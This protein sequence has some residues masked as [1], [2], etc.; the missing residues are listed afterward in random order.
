MSSQPPA[1]QNQRRCSFCSRDEDAVHRLIAGPEGVFICNECVD[2]CQDILEGERPSSRGLTPTTD[3]PTLSPQEI[4]DSLDEYVVGQEKAKRVLSVAVY[5]HY[6][7]IAN[8]G[9]GEV[10]LEKTN[11]L[12]VGPTGSGKTLL[13]Q[14][15]AKSLDVP[16]CI[17]DA[18]AL[19]EAGYVGEDVENILLRLLHAA[20]FN[21]PRAERGIGYIDE[22]DKTARKSGDNPSITRDVSGEGVQ[23]ALLKIIEGTVVNVP[24]QGGRKHPQQEFIQVDTNDILFI[25][26]GLFNGLG[27]IVSQRIGR[28]GQLGFS[29][30]VDPT[31]THSL[32]ENGLLEVISPDDLMRYGMIPELVGRLPVLTY[33]HALD[34]DALRSIL[35]APK[36]ALVRQYQ[37]LFEM[38]QVEL[39]FTEEALNEA[40]RLAQARE[41]GARG[42][43]SIIEGTLL[44]V[45]YEIPSRPEVRKVVVDEAAVKS[46]ARPHLYNDEGRELDVDDETLPE[47]A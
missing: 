9:R 18:T 32:D 14:T 46:E 42:L 37:R 39:E 11:I 26:G 22:I 40:A 17:A 21:I 31:N 44:D 33:V 5:N 12:I 34:F 16:F 1:E 29:G 19:T 3:R 28:R 4:Y 24:P 30:I 6:K 25:C 36:N 15:L 27:D 7:R 38:D 8:R 43:R 20:D 35:T 10:E 13:A 23:Q 45:M 41:T 47:A 2:L